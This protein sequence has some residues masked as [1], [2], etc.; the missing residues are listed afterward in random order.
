MV[1]DFLALFTGRPLLMKLAALRVEP[2]VRMIPP[3]E[4]MTPCKTG[5]PLAPPPASTSPV[6]VFAG[7]II[8]VS[9]MLDS[10]PVFSLKLKIWGFVI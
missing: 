6:V 5:L 1:S 9:L 4:V 3:E 10:S 8:D 7:V 2:G